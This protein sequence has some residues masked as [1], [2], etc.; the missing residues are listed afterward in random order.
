MSRYNEEEWQRLKD[1]ERE[2]Q[3]R[4]YQNKFLDDTYNQYCNEK[5]D[6]NMEKQLIKAD[7]FASIEEG[8]FKRVG[9]SNRYWVPTICV[10]LI[11]G[12]GF[13][14]A[15]FYQ[16][17]FYEKTKQDLVSV[18]KELIKM[19]E[20]KEKKETAKNVNFAKK[21]KRTIWEIYKGKACSKGSCTYSIE[22]KWRDC[23]RATGRCNKADSRRLERK[24]Y[25]INKTRTV[26]L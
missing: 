25:K 11:M 2:R 15:G 8:E 6:I 17:F 22:Q 1:A 14:F 21:W 13:L 23:Y 16:N 12:C 4:K 5:K 18:S 10:V 24:N 26:Y 7:D 19:T 20:V 3:K 9:E